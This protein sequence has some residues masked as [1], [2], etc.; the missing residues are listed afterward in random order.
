MLYQP[1]QNER[2]FLCRASKYLKQNIDNKPLRATLSDLE[3]QLYM[4]WQSKPILMLNL[5]EN[6]E[7]HCKPWHLLAILYGTIVVLGIIFQITKG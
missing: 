7:Q 3:Y 6:F 2:V 4:Q 5:K 1:F